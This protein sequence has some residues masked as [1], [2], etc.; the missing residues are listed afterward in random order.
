MIAV[1][2]MVAITVVLAAI[3][4]TWAS[5]LADAPSGGP[6]AGCNQGSGNFVQMA[7]DPPRHT[8]RDQAEYRMTSTD[9]TV[10]LGAGN[11]DAHSGTSDD[12]ERFNWSWSPTNHEDINHGDSVQIAFNESGPVSDGEEFN[13]DIRDGHG[14]LAQCKFT[15]TA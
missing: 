5:G 7:A 14:T 9:G 8:R 13:F 2:L 6:Q 15:W 1:I 10:Y 4:Y 11:D 12:P 3:V